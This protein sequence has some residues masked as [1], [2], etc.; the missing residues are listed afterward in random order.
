[1]AA[2]IRTLINSSTVS[3]DI[4][5]VET[6]PHTLLHMNMM[7]RLF[8]RGRFIHVVRDGRDVVSSLLQRDW[9]DPAT[10]EKVWCCK[11]PESAANYWTHVVDAIRTQAETVE[12][13]YLEVRYEELVSH[14]EAVIRQVLAFL[15]EPWDPSVLSDIQVESEAAPVDL[16]SVGELFPST[17]RNTV[18]ESGHEESSYAGK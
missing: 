9:M 4:R 1:M 15:G 13:R 2:F 14:P 12:G 6:T 16:D 5:K 10:G 3:T 8:P 17:A 7:G 11:D 18:G